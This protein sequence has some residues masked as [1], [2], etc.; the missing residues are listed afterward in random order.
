MAK[1]NDYYGMFSDMADC[2]HRSAQRLEETLSQFKASEIKKDMEEMHKLENE[3][4]DHKHELVKLLA[5]EFITPIE[6]EDIIDIASQI[7][8]IT[9][10][11]EDVL[12][13]M[14][15]YNV[16]D[17]R[18]DAMQFAKIITQCCEAMVMVFKELSNFKKSKKIHDSIIEIN[19]LEE[20]GDTLYIRATRDLFMDH[21][22]AKAAFAWAEI[23]NCLEKCCD[24]CEH[25]ADR[26]ENV[27]MKNS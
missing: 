26:V 6:R 4:D 19:R 22:D 25:T 3:G 11:I 16:Q 1:K 10:S 20:M 21:M 13:K 24:T 14:Y 15:I 2:A 18:P 17:I 23:Y 5:K 12:I 9:D 8:D 7:D 27:I